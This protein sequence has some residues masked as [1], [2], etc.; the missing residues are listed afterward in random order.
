MAGR[1]AREA[2]VK[3]VRVRVAKARGAASVRLLS[4]AA[5]AKKLLPSK[6][7]ATSTMMKAAN[8]TSIAKMQTVK[9]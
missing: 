7:A 2:A 3:A 8:R 5:K 4:H 1:K 9:P 6:A